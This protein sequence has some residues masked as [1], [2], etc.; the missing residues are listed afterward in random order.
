[1]KKLS[2]LLT[3]LLVLSSFSAFFTVGTSAAEVDVWDGT[4]DISWYD[5]NEISF[6]IT[7]PEQLAGLAELGNMGISFE[8]QTIYLGADMILNTGNAANW[9]AKRADENDPNSQFVQT[10]APANK[11]TPI[12][13]IV[14]F[15]GTF[16][17]Q[18]HVISGMYYFGAESSDSNIGLFS[19]IGGTSE[20]TK[21]TVK[22][23]SIINSYLNGYKAVGSIAGYVDAFA[24][25]EGCYS[26]AN[27][28]T[29][30]YN[31]SN[32]GNAHGCAVSFCGG[33]AGQLSTAPLDVTFNNCW[34]AGSIYS[35]SGNNFGG[36]VGGNSS[37]EDMD[38][39]FK[40]TNCAVTGSVIC[41]QRAG[42]L[43]GRFA[44]G[45]QFVIED[46]YVNGTIG[47]LRTANYGAAIGGF[48]GKAS[49]TVLIDNMYFDGAFLDKTGA[50]TGARLGCFEE[51][52]G[53]PIGQLADGSTYYTPL[54]DKSA[55]ASGDDKNLHESPDLMKAK[56]ASI[57]PFIAGL[58]TTLWGTKDGA[59]YLKTL[60]T[61]AGTVP[62]TT[63]LPAGAETL[64][65]E[66]TTVAPETTAAPV[67]TTAAP[68]E[69]TAAPV[70]TTA[71]PVETTAAPVETTAAPAE[72][73]AAP[74]VEDT[75]AAPTVDDTTAAPAEGGCGCFIGGSIVVA[76]AIL[77]SAWVS[78]RR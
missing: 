30:W 23:V 32:A 43:V 66:E 60:T 26:D 4:S 31:T 5:Q 22:N 61:V 10:E 1:M 12:C 70:E 21:A 13:N 8:G 52:G 73:T 57:D 54:E 49:S 71:A 29:N 74:A 6:L 37:G 75:T 69:T 20:E 67:E 9:D 7:T 56:D 33:M 3:V 46:C 65:K 45:G 78:K 2:V 76:T 48:R 63:T 19:Q 38:C 28:T 36:I 51:S 11:W 77:G 17:G 62:A 47:Y 59:P 55:T 53:A 50:P 41:D 40:I 64:P 25:I 35:W 14:P 16:D 68:V 27:L 15:S 24:T 34:Y 58:D 72:T 18:G 39:N 42:G 44:C